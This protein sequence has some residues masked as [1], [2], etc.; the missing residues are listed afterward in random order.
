MTARWLLCL[1]GFLVASAAAV[2]IFMAWHKWGSSPPVPPPDPFAPLPYS[3]S[4]YLNTGPNARYVGTDACVRCHGDRHA[5]YLLT[6]HSRALA[7]LDP[8]KEP[9]DGAFFHELSGRFYRVYRQDGQFRHEEI[10]RTT[11]G[12]EI[13]RVDMPI[14]YL[15][16]SGNFCRSYLFEDDG[17]L[18]E[19]PITWYT[20]K[21]KWDMSPGYDFPQ[22]WSFERPIRL[23]CAACHAGRVEAQGDAVHRLTFHEKA[24]GCENCHGP[25]SLH[26]ALHETSRHVLGTEDLTIVNPARLSRPLQEAICAACHLNG[27][28]SIYL[29]GR[30][31]TDFR[32][33]MPLSDYRT[34]YRLDAA[35][36]RMT[37]VGHM[38]QLRQSVCYQKSKDLTCLT[39]HD[40]HLPE[41]PTEGAATTAFYREKCLNC[42]SAQ[43]CRLPESER[44]KK[45]A[46]DNCMVCHM[47]RGD[48]D[49]PHVAFT[50]HRIGLHSAKQPAVSGLAPTLAPTDDVS[51]LPVL[52]QQRNLGLAYMQAADNSVYAAYADDFRKKARGLLEPVHK[53]GLREGETAFALAVLAWRENPHLASA[54]AR[55]ALAAKDVSPYLRGLSLNLLAE[56]EMQESNFDSAIARLEELVRLRRR[57]EDWRLLGQCYRLV[58]QPEKALEALNHALAIRPSSPAVH[59]EF[60]TVYRQTG[61][62]ARAKEH[63]EKAQWLVQHHQE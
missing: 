17:F 20:G 16:G 28:A 57:A 36:D 48:T 9:P 47:P 60:E 29:R 51:H 18:H 34:D 40:P 2:G 10:L 37:V 26:L 19:S 56:L 39:C 3:A 14:R 59:S 38:E 55:E 24:I 42:H 53:A 43:G 61:D 7:D 30:R 50:H 58:R 35:N 1:L 44:L 62:L 33:G 54:F 52:D 27:P 41:K 8:A 15:I 31:E 63:Q 6:P 23:G 49:I 11:E 12:K 46:A 13:A 32:P 21:H 4:R 45:D 22:H 25:G 5:S